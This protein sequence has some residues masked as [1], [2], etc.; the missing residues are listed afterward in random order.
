MLSGL[1]RGTA[2]SSVL[3]D[4]PN[5]SI[6]VLTPESFVEPELLPEVG[7]VGRAPSELDAGDEPVVVEEVLRD[8]RLEA[9]ERVELVEVEP[10]MTELA[11]ESLDH[12]VGL[13][14]VDLSDDVVGD[15]S[16]ASP[17]KSQTL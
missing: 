5:A 10:A 15:G 2:S 7:L 8:E 9:G 4:S 13:D 12:R 17:Q 1:A 3:C 6:G 14:D 11:P 16:G